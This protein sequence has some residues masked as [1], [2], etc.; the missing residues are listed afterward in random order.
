MGID[1]FGSGLVLPITMLYLVRVVGIDVGVAGVL[2]AGGSVVGL[3]VPAL[4]SRGVDSVGPRVLV[5]GSQGIQAIGMAT[6]FGADGP[7]MAT[8]G[9][10]LSAAGL[11]L[12]YSSMSALVADVVED[13]PKDHAFAMVTRVRGASFGLGA[14]AGGALA[15]LGDPAWMRAGVAFNGVTLILALS[16]LSLGVHGQRR[17]AGRDAPGADTAPARVLSSRPFIGLMVVAFCSTLPIDFFLSGNAIYVTDY[18][19]M[20]PW[21]IGFGVALLT[22]FSSVFGS[23]AVRLTDR[24][25]RITTQMIAVVLFLVWALVSAAAVHLPSG[26]RTATVLVLAVLIAFAN[27]VPMARLAAMV[28]ATAPKSHKGRFLAVF[29]YPF[30]IA[31][32]VGPGLTSLLAVASW[33]PWVIIAVLLV[34]A[35]LVLGWLRSALPHH[36]VRVEPISAR[37]SAHD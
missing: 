23:V 17:P 37:M 34:V 27:V 22:V 19:G 33:V 11:Q 28:E 6:F 8:A 18:L 1:N 32:V 16:L 14:L 21:V 20:D 13:G 7:V 12:F 5:I 25:T 9:I 29:Q 30:S 4:A 2:V 10:V 36:A 31:Q 3:A 24:Y 35:L 15:S 26:V